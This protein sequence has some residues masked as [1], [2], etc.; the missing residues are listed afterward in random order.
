MEWICGGSEG[1]LTSIG[2]STRVT[3]A[4]SFSENTCKEEEEEEGEKKV[5][6]KS[7]RK[8]EKQGEG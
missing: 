5:R 4:A 8:W 7:Q 1:L 2:I 3:T 6:R